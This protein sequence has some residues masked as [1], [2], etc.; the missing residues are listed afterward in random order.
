MKTFSVLVASV[1]LLLVG[2]KKTNSANSDSAAKQFKPLKIMAGGYSSFDSTFY[3]YDVNN[4]LVKIYGG[5]NTFLPPISITRDQSGMI[6]GFVQ[7]TFIGHGRAYTHTVNGEYQS[8]MQIN[9]NSAQWDSTAFTTQNGKI[10]K[11]ET[12]YDRGYWDILDQEFFTYDQ[13]GNLTNA[14]VYATD[15]ITGLWGLAEEITYTYD[16]EVNPLPLGNDALLIFDNAPYTGANN[17]V[18]RKIDGDTY[19][20]KY[21][22]SVNR[23]PVTAT[24]TMNSSPYSEIHFL[25]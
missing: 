18:S 25:F 8:L 16:N 5:G 23:E 17:F 1:F 9:I 6:T 22:Y 7:E 2:C 12:F 4:R 21:T 11:S 20:L 24:E 15:V 14:K 10:I 13:A 3:Q 19:S